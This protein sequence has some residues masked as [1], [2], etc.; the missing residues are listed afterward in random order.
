MQNARNKTLFTSKLHL[1]LRKKLVKCYL[2]SIA[3]YGAEIWTLLKAD[4]KYLDMYE[5]WCWRWM[6]KII[7]TD[8]VRNEKVYTESRRR[9]IFY[10][11]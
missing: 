9:G 11:Q 3:P 4:Q 8:H 1:N 10:I 5:M 2:W 7:W 6:E